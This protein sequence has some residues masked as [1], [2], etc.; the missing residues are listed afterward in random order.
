MIAALP[1]LHPLWSA[2]L[3]AAPGD[4]TVPPLGA[5]PPAAGQRV[6]VTAPEYAGTAVHHLLYLPPAWTAAAV[7][8][9][10]RWPVV[11]EY[12]GNQAPTLGSSGL[13]EGAALGYG[14]T[15]GRAIWLVLPYVAADH[16]RNQ[17]TWWGD[18]GATLDYARREVPRSCAAWGGDPA[19]VLL[20]GFSRGAIGVNYLGLHDDRIAPLWCGLVSHDHYDGERE[21]GGT[22][23]GAPLATYRAAATARLQRHAGR[24]AL[25]CQNGGTAG[26]RDYLTG[27]VDLASFTFLDVPVSQIL[28]PFP[29][30]LAIH[31]H[32]DRWLLRPSPARQ[33][34]WNWVTSVTGLQLQ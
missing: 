10:Q 21:W 15:A 17:E 8:A 4:L 25:V 31:P 6:S 28:G 5:G 12:T 1:L 11:V 33:T 23:W 26:L 19:R 27:R 2:L 29:N 14:L 30:D 18:V 13:V 34:A 3:L 16:Q 9:G 32:T 7:A 20:C 24:P 22:T